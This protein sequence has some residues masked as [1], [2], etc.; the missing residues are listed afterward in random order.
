MVFDECMFLENLTDGMSMSVFGIATSSCALGFLQRNMNISS[1]KVKEQANKS[2]VRPSLEYACSVWDPYTKENITQ[3]ERVQ[4]IGLLGMLLT[5]IITIVY[6]AIPFK[7]QLY[8]DT[9]IL[10]GFISMFKLVGVHVGCMYIL[11]E[12]YFV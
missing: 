8:C 6:M 1:T 3:L 11:L 5:T 12:F 7:V 2:L 4:H 9:Q 10:I